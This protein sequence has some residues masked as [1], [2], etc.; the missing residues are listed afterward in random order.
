VL[1]SNT[2]AVAE[3]LIS[4]VAEGRDQEVKARLI[5][6]DL[7]SSTKVEIITEYLLERGEEGASIVYKLIKKLDLQRDDLCHVFI[8]AA[9]SGAQKVLKCLLK[10]KPGLVDAHTL[11]TAFEAAVFGEKC[12]IIQMLGSSRQIALEIRRQAVTPSIFRKLKGSLEDGSARSEM[13]LAETLIAKEWRDQRESFRG[14]RLKPPSYREVQT[15]EL[16]N[17]YEANI[18]EVEKR[19]R[20]TASNVILAGGLDNNSES[21]ELLLE[22]CV[23]EFGRQCERAI[24]ELDRRKN[25]RFNV[26]QGKKSQGQ[27]RSTNPNGCEWKRS[28]AE[29]V[30]D[31]FRLY[32]NGKRLSWSLLLTTIVKEWGDEKKRF[33]ALKLSDH[34]RQVHPEGRSISAEELSKCLHRKS[35]KPTRPSIRIL[36]EAFK[37]SLAHELMIWR[38][39]GGESFTKYQQLAENYKTSNVHKSTGQIRSD[40]FRSLMEMSGIS[41]SR[42][43]QLLNVQQVAVWRHGARIEDLEMCEKLVE[44]VNPVTL[45]PQESRHLQREIN[46]TLVG[47][48]SSRPT[49]IVEAVARAQASKHSTGT[50]FLLLTG[51]YGLKQIPVS[52]LCSKLRVSEW[53][54]H[55]MRSTRNQRGCHINE[56]QAHIIAD[57]VQGISNQ[58]RDSLTVVE[59]YERGIMIDTLTGVRDPVALWHQFASG[60][61]NHVGEILR[62]TRVRRGH[63]QLPNTSDFELG[64]SGVGIRVANKLADYLGYVGRAHREVRRA[65]VLMALGKDL[66]K[67]PEVILDSIMTGEC[68][69]LE[70]LRLMLD[71]TGRTRGQLAQDLGVSKAVVMTWVRSDFAGKISNPR[72]IRDLASELG[73]PNRVS[74][75]LKVFSRSQYQPM[76]LDR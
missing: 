70:G 52:E 10:D 43:E 60:K 41:A 19:I 73:I 65:F 46:E 69:R 31:L 8:A 7:P 24:Y 37:L 1:R 36:C 4:A 32:Q 45:W 2:S 28:V 29:V 11:R 39:V 22:L 68:S 59:R 51:R 42:I 13:G 57:V 75:M 34:I 26:L 14:K 71:N 72:L 62:L 30:E 58:M 44:L 12:D 25:N 47:L 55:R 66:P 17:L 74:D 5:A 67:S 49:S 63:V 15:Q 20:S 23:R 16:R 76:N 9:E 54:L 64:K 61:L 33:S 48:L 21:K 27:Y 3:Q 53:T 38:F 40:L 50:C 35:I 18:A 6:R 56:E